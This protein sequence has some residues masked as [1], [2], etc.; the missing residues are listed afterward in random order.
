[1]QLHKDITKLPSLTKAVLTIGSFDGV[2]LGHK[3][4]LQQLT[5]AA[6]AIDG[7]SVVISFFP[8]P[9]LFLGQ[10]NDK[11]IALLNTI[12]EK[13]TLMEKSGVDHLVL[14]PFTAEFASMEAEA[15]I[16][17]FLV[18]FFHPH[19][20]IIGHDHRFGKN[21][22][23]D[24]NLMKSCGIKYGFQ[25]LEIPEYVI[26][27]IG[28][29]STTIRNKL[30]S[31]DVTEANE[32]LGYQYSFTGTVIK[33]NQI[34]RTIGFPTAN[35]SIED[36]WKLIPCNG[37]YAVS[38][39]LKEKES[40]K[41]MMNIGNR[42]TFDGKERNIEVHIFE[43]HKEIYKEKLTIDIVKKIRDEIKFTNIDEL[44]AQLNTDKS[45]CLQLLNHLS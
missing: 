8:H 27:N 16:S 19:I 38:G 28:I 37:V 7:T 29:S 35:L 14:V 43:F 5:E 36:D 9:K 24:F 25:V 26:N 33:G 23:G 11:P 6:K 3:T 41:G 21:R 40:F 31:G 4:I 45:T 13:A 20:V 39:L 1:M 44:Q 42:P 34:G 15:Y 22:S 30:K 17:D 18:K 12:D 10:N 32:L 2:H